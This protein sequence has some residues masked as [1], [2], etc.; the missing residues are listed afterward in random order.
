MEIILATEMR[1]R[2]RL[3]STIQDCRRLGG[4]SRG[5]SLSFF[6]HSFCC[7]SSGSCEIASSGEFALARN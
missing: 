3:K 5:F 6:L 1:R 7:L 2:R 4:L